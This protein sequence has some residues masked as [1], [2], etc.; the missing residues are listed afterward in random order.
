MPVVGPSQLSADGETAFLAGGGELGALLRAHDWAATPL[1]SPATW[2]PEVKTAVSLCLNSRFP[3]VLWIGPELRILYNDAYI[4]FLGEAKH[5]AMLGAPGREAWGEIWDAIGPML[6]E[7]RSG[8]ATWVEDFQ[9]FFARRLPREE[10]YVTFSYS[11]IFAAG[12]H[13]VEG[14]FCACT[15]TTGRVIGERRLST[16]RGLGIR[17]S[18]QHTI[19]AA[20][21]GAASVLDANPWDVPFAA[22]YLCDSD[23]QTARLVA[24]TRLPPNDGPA[25]AFPDLHPLSHDGPSAT[26]PLAE[27]SRTRLPGEVADLPDRIAALASPLWPDLVETALVL[28][29]LVANQGAPAG[30]LV[31]GVSPRRV[32]DAEYRGFLGLVAEHVAGGMA[33]ARAFADEHRRAEALAEIDRAKTAFFSN[34]SHEFRTPLTLLL[35]PLEEILAKRGGEAS[36]ET[37]ALATVAHRNSLRLLRLVNTLLDFSRVE[38]GRAQ[39]CYEP[40]D[41]PRVTQELASSFESACAKA[42]LALEIV[43]EA[44]PEPVHVDPDMWEKIVLNLVSNAFK[45]TFEGRIAVRLKATPRGAELTVSDT[46]VGI[47]HAE[48]PRIFERFHR[49]QGQPSRSHEGSGIGLALVQEL[50]R[51]HGGTIA[52]RSKVGLGTTITTVLPF[53]TAH[54]PAER[55]GG[56]RTLLPGARGAA[57]FVEEA[58]RWLPD[59]GLMA[60]PPRPPHSADAAPRGTHPARIL[61]ADDNADMRD[62]LVR[63]LTSAGWEV[64]AVADGEAALAAARRRR[65]DLLLADVMMPG[66]GGLELAGAL[67]RERQFAEL[68]VLLLSARAGEEARIEGLE[69]G[70]DDYLVKPF[71]ARELL[72][73]AAS[74]LALARLRRDAAERVRRSERRLQAAIELVGLS[75]YAWDPRT[76]RL[77]WDDRLRAMWGL[78][79]GADVDEDVFRAGV[80]PADRQRVEAAIAACVDPAGDGVYHLDYRVI[81]IGDGVERWVSTHGR[82]AVD[83]AGRPVGF[84]G[85]ALDITERKR[86]EE[87]LRT[88]EER[89]R[90]FAAHSTNI[91]W[92]MDLETARVDY[93]SPAFEAVW[94]APPAT[95]LG[96]VARWAETVHPDDRAVALDALRRVGQGETVL[97][98]YRI[99]RPDGS[100]RRIRDTF[101]PIRDEQGRVRKAGGIAQDTTTHTGSL[102]YVVDADAASRARLSLLLSDAGYVVK[103]FGSAR[104]FL[105]VA[106]VLMPGCV[107]LDVGSP[108]AGG[109]TI[110]R[111]L[112]GRRSS[113][114]VIVTG[115][116]DVELAVQAMKAGAADWREAPCEPGALLTAVASLLAGI[117][118]VAQHDSAEELAR[119]RVAGISAREREVL[120]GLLAG[121]T[122]KTIARDLG[123]SPRTVE[124]HRARLMERLGAHSLPEL[125]LLAAAAGFTDGR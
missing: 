84:L 53:G 37:R 9:M 33:E 23:G 47:P 99:F 59:V 75:P 48:L 92:T 91:L 96:D 69:L 106:P 3:I 21:Q 16:L 95:A 65:P 107:V 66:L 35:G 2:S 79:P 110:P 56:T 120:L 82:T 18:Q 26:W 98:E 31:V 112:K 94:G 60:G 81:G 83:E 7:A 61:L 121:G 12:G 119:A 114:P 125:A 1:G 24:G 101:F 100:A 68:P 77:E 70:A 118:D 62:Y 72:A 44:L 58:L 117:E 93:V 54:L 50:V 52:A 109:L 28:P 103:T 104:A 90:Q 115:R 19:E 17:A 10:V 105:D 49:V 80:H 30:F 78:P 43:C 27:A 15:E 40:T 55:I 32:L 20:C 86:A 102:V 57:P 116:G 25:S 13:T 8:R 88:S 85:V 73:R 29:L 74:L 4:P 46:G 38:A 63:L 36:A 42:G 67:R 113:L 111:E 41:L 34:V 11:P 45:F 124:I 108:E 97:Q 89:F 64:E 51:L 87:Q 123:L 71:A 5:P 14:V 76:G 22:I 6:D 39:A 122:N